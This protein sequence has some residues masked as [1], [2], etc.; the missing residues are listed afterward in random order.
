M[1]KS[2]EKTRAASAGHTGRDAAIIVGALAIITVGYF[3]LRERQERPQ[4]QAAPMSMNQSGMPGSNMP[5][6]PT[7]YDGLVQAGNE[8]MDAGNY[9]VAAESYRRALDIDGSSTMVRTDFGACLHGMGLPERA[10]DEF[11]KVITQDPSHQFASFNMGIVFMGMN[12]PDSSRKYFEY[13]LDLNPS[14]EMAERARQLI[15]DLDS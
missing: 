3:L 13:C 2:K 8:Y 9:A 15:K 4:P 10:I 14:P 6:M 5:G 1:P 12:Q 11:R 7:D